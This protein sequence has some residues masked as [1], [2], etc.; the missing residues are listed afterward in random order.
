M[1]LRSVSTEKNR[2][3]G[4]KGPEARTRTVYWRK[5]KKAHVGKKSHI[6]LERRLEK[7]LGPAYRGTCMS[8]QG[9]GSLS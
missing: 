1:L 7:K 4:S 2:L 5:W 3:G 6:C 9:F 8:S